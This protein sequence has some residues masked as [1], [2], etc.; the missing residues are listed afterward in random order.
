MRSFKLH[1]FLT[2]L[3]V[4]LSILHIMDDTMWFG[5]FSALL[6]FFLGLIQFLISSYYVV[7]R[8]DVPGRIF[9]I[10]TVLSII[11]IAILLSNSAIDIDDFAFFTDQRFLL[12]MAPTLV[13]MLFLYGLFHQEKRGH[14]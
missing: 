14:R 12:R 7:K 10:H 13:A 5:V 4:L 2:A 1:I 8:E 6:M 9:L 11:L 3:L